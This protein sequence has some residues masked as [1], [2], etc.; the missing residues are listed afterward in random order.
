MRRRF[1]SKA[2]AEMAVFHFVEDWYNP[3]RRH[4]DIDHLSLIN[5]ERKMM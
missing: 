1:P 4:C 2:E 5:Y 3:H